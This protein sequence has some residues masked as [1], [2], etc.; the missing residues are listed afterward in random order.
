V[1]EFLSHH[2]VPFREIN[3][4]EDPQAREEMVRRSGHLAVPTTIIDGQV[5]IGYDEEKLRRLVPQAR[6]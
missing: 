4:A 1:K 3:V 2:G 6:G 5:I